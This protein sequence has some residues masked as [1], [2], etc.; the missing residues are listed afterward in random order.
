MQEQKRIPMNKLYLF[1]IIVGVVC[2]AYVYGANVADAKCRA[3]FAQQNLIALQNMQN[4][5]SQIKKENHEIVY[6]NSVADVRR[7]LRDKYTI[8]E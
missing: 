5:I 3:H 6:K 2:G 8:G 7:L 4:Q 1:F